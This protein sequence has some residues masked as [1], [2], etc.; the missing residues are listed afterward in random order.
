MLE[1]INSNKNWKTYFSKFEDAVKKS[2]LIKFNNKSVEFPNMVIFSTEEKGMIY[3]LLNPGVDILKTSEEDLKNMLSGLS[4][5]ELDV[6][7]LDTH[8]K[9]S[10]SV[11]LNLRLLKE[12][13]V[14]LKEYENTFIANN[15]LFT[16]SKIE[17]EG[18]GLFTSKNEVFLV[19][20][21]DFVTIKNYLK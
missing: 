16:T 20:E 5:K 21:E 9:P 4:V 15:I 17:F 2:V 14:Y 1:L 6:I 12:Q 3:S 7:F 13:T 18:S 10:A 8:T 19:S 11:R